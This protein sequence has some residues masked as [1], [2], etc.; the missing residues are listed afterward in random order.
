M[1][2]MENLLGLPHSHTPPLTPNFPSDFLPIRERIFLLFF[3][4]LKAIGGIYYQYIFSLFYARLNLSYPCTPIGGIYYQYIFS[5]FFIV[6]IACPDGSFKSPGQAYIIN[7]FYSL[8][9]QSSMPP[10]V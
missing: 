4:G 9:Y 8:S 6:I 3:L 7:I 5:L 2:M 1:E 10:Q